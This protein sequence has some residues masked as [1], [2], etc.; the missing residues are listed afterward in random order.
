[1]TLISKPEG[2]SLSSSSRVG[3]K[4]GDKALANLV[5][6]ERELVVDERVEPRGSGFTVKSTVAISA[7]VG[8]SL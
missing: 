6:V 4:S 7:S 1:M 5:G 8:E 3:V 2:V